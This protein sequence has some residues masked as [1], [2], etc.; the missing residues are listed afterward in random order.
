VPELLSEQNLQ[1][2]P[3][4]APLPGQL[5]IAPEDNADLALKSSNVGGR[6]ATDSLEGQ[7]KAGAP[8]GQASSLG[9]EGEAIDVNGASGRLVGGATQS[10]QGASR[11]AGLGTQD[12]ADPNRADAAPLP[13]EQEEVLLPPGEYTK[14]KRI[15]VQV[16]PATADA[17]STSAAGGLKAAQPGATAPTP[18][19][20]DLPSV[21]DQAV[22]SRFF[23]HGEG[24]GV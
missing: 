18:V 14:G 3:V 23:T 7:A 13:P 19:N 16:A 12:L 20:R 11:T 5:T 24:G 15:R 6:N 10:G 9:N 21:R 4:P 22:F 1:H 2:A 8:A 17:N